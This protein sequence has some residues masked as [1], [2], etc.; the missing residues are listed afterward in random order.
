MLVETASEA[1][2]Q[3]RID[4][5]AAVET[6][7][8]L[9][10]AQGLPGDAEIAAHHMETAQRLRCGSAAGNPYMAG[11]LGEQAAAAHHDLPRGDGQVEPDR[12]RRCGWWWSRLTG[13]VHIKDRYLNR[14]ALRDADLGVQNVDLSADCE[15]S[16]DLAVQADVGIDGRRQSV[17]RHRA[18]VVCG[19]LQ[20]ERQPRRRNVDRA[21]HA[22]RPRPRP[23][24]DFGSAESCFLRLR[25]ARLC[26]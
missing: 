20:I 16:D 7:L 24:L 26:R 10:K 14:H 5:T 15:F 8:A 23:A 4:Q 17:A 2:I 9:D 11:K 12:R 19:D 25:P 1:E 22:D 21:A 3:A 13:D 6:D 18:R